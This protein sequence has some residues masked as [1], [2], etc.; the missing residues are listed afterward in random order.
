MYNK[1]KS[2]TTG[3]CKRHVQYSQNITR[4]KIKKGRR[5]L[6]VPVEGVLRK[7][8]RPQVNPKKVKHPI[9]FTYTVQASS[10]LFVLPSPA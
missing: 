4:K 7:I 9:A 3:L 10:F 8:K 1:Y 6:P 2:K 5:A